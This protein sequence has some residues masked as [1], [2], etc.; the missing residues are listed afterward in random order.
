MFRAEELSGARN[1]GAKVVVDPAA[2]DMHAARCLDGSPPTYYHRSTRAVEGSAEGKWLLYFQGGGWCV[3][4]TG[5]NAPF[6][7]LLVDACGERAGTLLGS[8]KSDTQTKDFGEKPLFSQDPRQNPAFHDWHVVFIRY[9]DGASFADKAGYANFAAILGQLLT[10]GFRDATDV[11]VSGCSAGALAAAI[12]ADRVQ[13]ALPNAFVTAL[14][15]SGLFPDWSRQVGGPQSQAPSGVWALHEQLQR[16]FGERG[17]ETSGALPAECFRFHAS[18]PWRC[19]FLEFLLPFV[20]VPAFVLQS[21]FDSSNVRSIDSRKGLEALGAGLE[22]RV[23]EALKG[24]PQRHGFFL[25]SCF[26]HCMDWGQIVAAD[27]KTQPE[28]FGVWRRHQAHH[29]RDAELTGQVP[30]APAGWDHN[31]NNESVPCWDASHCKSSGF[32]LDFWNRTFSGASAVAFSVART[33]V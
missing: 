24:G 28:A 32:D 3:P 29:R 6:P 14:L 13:A 31:P 7:A 10:E 25:D 33:A 15:D 26:H 11:V 18:A 9:C 12:H 17:L 5:S 8:T 2:V 4:G 19:F 16:V 23:T 27:G 30:A 20:K 22:W 1:V 21:R